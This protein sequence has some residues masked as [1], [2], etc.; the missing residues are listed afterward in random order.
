MLSGG[1]FVEAL[2][3]LGYPGASSLKAS[4]FDW[5]FDCAPENLHFLRFVCRTLNSSNVLTAE[6]AS[7]FQALRR[8]G[9][10]ILDEASLAKVLKTVGPS[11]GGGS[12]AS[13][14]S[15]FAAEGDVTTGDL[16]AE[17]QALRKEKELKQRRY[18]R[19]QV[20][21][22]SIADDDLHLSAELESAASKLKDA[23]ASVGAENAH[24]NA[25][26]R[27]LTDE[28]DDLAS[29]LSLEPEGGARE[30]VSRRRLP[31]TPA[32][33]LSQ[34][35]LDPY[36]QQEELNTKTLAA[37][38]HKQL[39]VS[40]VAET[41]CCER[42]RPLDLSS[43]E[44]GEDEEEEEEESN[45]EGGPSGGARRVERRR[46]E[47]ARL[48]WAHVVARHQLLRAKAEEESVEAGL[49]WLSQTSTNVQVHE[50][51]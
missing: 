2:G 46:T 35:S 10:A 43:R 17:L 50:T 15:T 18:S 24:T 1:Q 4:E 25:G 19:L 12:S 31:R 30:R 22:T 14:S 37:F 7:A 38:T 29:Y 26:L 16:E 44:A 3:R 20:A 8:S 33:L 32:V 51:L 11:E 6:E 21:A 13:P 47:V 28:V 40:G 49:D 39:F 5:L 36:L 27:S 34:M 42:L 9:K 48:Q 45:D 41:S 23:G